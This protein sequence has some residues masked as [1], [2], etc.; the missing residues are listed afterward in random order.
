MYHQ[1]PL[2][3]LVAQDN[4]DCYRQLNTTHQHGG[5]PQD[6]Y[7]TWSIDDSNSKCEIIWTEIKT[8]VKNVVVGSYYRPPRADISALEYLNDSICKIKQKCKEK[9]II[10][11]EILNNQNKSKLLEALNVNKAGGPD[12]IPNKELAPAPIY[13]NFT[14]RLEKRKRYTYI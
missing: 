5:K 6:N 8:E 9:I 3:H 7:Q 4:A 10:L 2:Q 1:Y 13:K 12:S 14:T 11:A